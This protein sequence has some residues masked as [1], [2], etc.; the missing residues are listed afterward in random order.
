VARG[1]TT[2]PPPA[3]RNEEQ[4]KKEREKRERERREGQKRMEAGKRAEGQKRM[5]AEKER[6]PEERCREKSK[7]TA[8]E[9]EET[10]ETA[11]GEWTTAGG[12]KR[13]KKSTWADRADATTEQERASVAQ[14][15]RRPRPRP[16]RLVPVDKYPRAEREVLV[17]FDELKNPE[18]V[19]DRHLAD[20]ALR[21]VNRAILNHQDV[22]QFP[23]HLARVTGSRNIALTAAGNVRGVV[24]SDYV[25]VIAEALKDYGTCTA[26]VHEKWSKFL[27]RG[28]PA[29]TEMEGIREDIERKYPGIRLAQSPGWLVPSARREGVAEATVIIA[30]LGQVPLSRLG[31]RI[32][33]GSQYCTVEQYYEYT[34]YTQCTRCQKYGHVAERCKSPHP[35]CAVCADHH[36]TKD[37]PCTESGCRRGPACMHDLKCANCSA[38]HKARD[39]LCPHRHNAYRAYHKRRGFSDAEATTAAAQFVEFDQ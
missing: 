23:F 37:H 3:Q 12:S 38:P 4:E 27:V 20:L 33:I 7:E 9:T 10:E 2:A 35:K 34:D 21:A 36:A 8:V 15:Q 6:A 32:A 14:L 16:R 31:K 18:G 19:N 24:Y 11:E 29:W 22:K 17:T 25:N 28:V 26:K 30:L 13:S 1:T 39:R 5:E